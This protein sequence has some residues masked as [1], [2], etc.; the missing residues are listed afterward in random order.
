MQI[1]LEI[2]L[3]HKAT[4]LPF[5]HRELFVLLLMHFCHA[6][7]NFDRKSREPSSRVLLM[8]SLRKKLVLLERG[9]ASVSSKV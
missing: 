9:F 6:F 2:C 8:W 3:V 7:P 5:Q 4:A 1:E